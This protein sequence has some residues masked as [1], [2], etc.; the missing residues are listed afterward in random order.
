MKKSNFLSALLAVSVSL[1][2][3]FKSADL[4]EGIRRGLFLCSYSV[5][6]SLFP[7]MALSVFLC[8]SKASVFFEA[9]F[10]PLT[11]LLKI[12]SACGSILFASLIGGH[13][14]GAKC[15]ND[16]VKNG[17]LDQKTASKM[18]CYCV[19]AG[20]PFVISA[21]SIG[22]FGKI[23]AGIYILSAQILSAVLIAFLVTLLSKNSGF[24]E[25]NFHDLKKSNASCV[26]ESVISAA[27][28]C[29]RMC[30]FIVIFSGVLEIVFSGAVFSALSE[31]PFLKAVLSGFFEVTSGCFA[32]GNIEGFYG[33]ILAGAL[34]SF[35]GLSV[36]LQIAA[37]TEESKIPLFP[38]VVSRFFHALFTTG[39]LSV[40]LSFGGKAIE[41][42]SVK[43]GSIDAVFSASAP[44]AVS[45]LCMA[46]LFLL[47]IVPEKSEKEP[48]LKRIWNKFTEFCNS[49][50]Q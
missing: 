31:N 50:T 49:K 43:G 16:F 12:P 6:P 18:L 26:V 36:I 25:S 34:S 3:L 35:S 32:C 28:S 37:V 39:F 9:A 14:A 11:R 27:E 20:P 15:I 29:F 41:T 45:L 30:A 5:I 19:N 46:S 22:V 7:F 10:K 4:G 47:S 2:L 17:I 38:F 1:I 33:I 42:F 44:V 24:C 48:A 23:E 21:I 13:P 40:F 8:K